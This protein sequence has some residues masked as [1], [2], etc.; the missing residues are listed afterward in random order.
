MFS[1]VKTM[2]LGFPVVPEVYITVAT[3]RAR[4]AAAR[5]AAR[6][7][8]EVRPLADHLVE[9]EQPVPLR[10][11]GRED[12]HLAQLREGGQRRQHLRDL[13]LVRG[14]QHASAGVLQHVDHLLRQRVGGEREVH[15]AVGEAGEVAQRRLEAVL[16]EDRDLRVRL[17]V[18]QREHAARDGAGAPRQVGHGELAGLL[19]DDAEGHGARVRLLAR[20]EHLA[21]GVVG[22]VDQREQQPQPGVDV[23]RRQQR[24]EGAPADHVEQDGDRA[25]RLGPRGSFQPSRNHLDERPELRESAGRAAARAPRVRS[26]VSGSGISA[27]AQRSASRGKGDSCL[28]W[29]MRPQQTMEGVPCRRAGLAARRRGRA[30][31]HGPCRG[32]SEDVGER[33]SASSRGMAP[34]EAVGVGPTGRLVW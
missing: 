16:G 3:S 24:R 26:N 19:P 12:H 8:V 31:P 15:D 34:G 25:A 5:A 28:T 10:R 6:V 27:A 29:N 1:W 7:V 18:H 20:A 9:G 21:E 32:R 33:A 4:T 14:E 22:R 2:P 17:A 30:G 13:L 23:G 11:G